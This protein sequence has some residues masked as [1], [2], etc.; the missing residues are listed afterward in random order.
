MGAVEEMAQACRTLLTDEEVWQETSDAARRRAVEEF[1]VSR[2]LPMY[3]EL[4]D[5][6]LEGRAV[7]GTSESSGAP[8]AA[9]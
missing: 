5:D 4:Y 2:V 9:S 6:V 7:A 1:S 8:E 3:E